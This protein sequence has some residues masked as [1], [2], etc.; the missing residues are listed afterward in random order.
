MK[1]VYTLLL[2]ITVISPN[3]LVLNAM[4]MESDSQL[5]ATEKRTQEFRT[6]LMQAISDQNPVLVEAILQKAGSGFNGNFET[7]DGITPLGLAIFRVNFDTVA[8]LL[9]AGAHP[10][11]INGQGATA[12]DI[13]EMMLSAHLSIPGMSQEVIAELTKIR[14]LLAA[15]M[16]PAGY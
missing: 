11:M 15:S 14:E 7:E 5:V 3:I 10:N 9:Q 16:A 13:L 12:M 4:E 2:A 1:L 6:K 8:L